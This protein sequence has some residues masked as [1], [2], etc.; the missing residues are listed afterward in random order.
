MSVR[1]RR[2]SLLTCITDTYNCMHIRSRLSVTV[3]SQSNKPD[4]RVH[5]R[6]LMTLACREVVECASWEEFDSHRPPQLCNQLPYAHSPLHHTCRPAHLVSLSH[7]R[8]SIATRTSTRERLGFRAGTIESERLEARYPDHDDSD[9]FF[10]RRALRFNSS[11][12]L[13]AALRAADQLR[14][15]NLAFAAARRQVPEPQ[16]S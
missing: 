11:L 4:V 1:G 15:R 9:A 7:P 16:S 8:L 10:A 2:K 3:H 13:R 12:Q 5:C 14:S 6:A